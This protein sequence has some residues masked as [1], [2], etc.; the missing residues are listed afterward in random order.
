MSWHSILHA[1]VLHDPQFPHVTAGEGDDSADDGIGEG[2]GQVGLAT[3]TRAKPKK[4]SQ[5]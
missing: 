4:P 2:E 1:D 3:K 5:Y